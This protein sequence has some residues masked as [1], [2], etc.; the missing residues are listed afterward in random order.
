MSFNSRK[1][2]PGKAYL[3]PKHVLVRVYNATMAVDGG[4]S[5]EVIAL[6]DHVDSFS[7]NDFV[8]GGGLPCLQQYIV[9]DASSLAIKPRE[10]SFADAARLYTA[11]VLNR[12]MRHL[13]KDMQVLIL[14]DMSGF[15]VQ[16]ARERG[17]V[18]TASEDF[19]CG[20]D[21]IIEEDNYLNWLQQHTNQF[22]VVIDATGDLD[23]YDY[24][25]I[26]TTPLSEYISLDPQSTVQAVRA[27]YLPSLLGGGTR[28][29]KVVRAQK[30]EA[31]S[32]SL[33]AL[34]KRLINNEIHVLNPRIVAFDK[35]NTVMPSQRYVTAVNVIKQSDITPAEAEPRDRKGKGKGKARADPKHRRNRSSTDVQ[36]L[37]PPATPPVNPYS[38]RLPSRLAQSV[39]ATLPEDIREDP[40]DIPLRRMTA[41]SKVIDSESTIVPIGE[42]LE[43]EREGLLAETTASFTDDHSSSSHGSGPHYVAEDLSSQPRSFSPFVEEKNGAD[44]TQQQIEA[45]QQ[46]IAMLQASKAIQER[47]I[48]ASPI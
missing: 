27:L 19:D 3:D 32:K 20:E 1:P 11:S 25:E 16:F 6:G 40:S 43:P 24:C 9:V 47:A 26:F 45:L 33:S 41:S 10:L 13:E 35:I 2:C 34:A 23:L 7:V 12:A 36:T 18:V 38:P 28:K 21:I 22:D 42:E 31:L 39:S 48:A 4:F 8:F 17:C 29:L 14:D 37:T 44:T 46:Q 15:A 5:G 30:G